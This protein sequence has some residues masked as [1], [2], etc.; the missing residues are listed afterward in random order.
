MTLVWYRHTINPT[1]ACCF[2]VVLVSKPNCLCC[3]SLVRPLI[4]FLFT[5]FCSRWPEN[6]PHKG[7]VTLKMFPF[8]DVI[9]K[10]ATITSKPCCSIVLTYGND[11]FTLWVFRGEISAGKTCVESSLNILIMHRILITICDTRETWSNI[12]TAWQH[13]HSECTYGLYV[14]EIG[15]C[16]DNLWQLIA[17]CPDA[18]EYMK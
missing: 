12:I 10:N 13:Q 9:M 7:S 5:S 11:I 15:D 3:Q 8:D 17:N 2:D 4:A 16:S 14:N 18:F 1:Q 6:S